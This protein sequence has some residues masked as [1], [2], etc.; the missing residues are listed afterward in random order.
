MLD[1][2]LALLG[3]DQSSK[4]PGAKKDKKD[5]KLLQT[6]FSTFWATRVTKLARVILAERRF[7]KRT[8]L[9]C[10]EDLMKLTLTYE[11][12]RVV[13]ET[14]VTRLLVYNRCR[15]GELEDTK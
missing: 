15:S 9:P 13:M 5:V 3:F 2:K 6:A 10:P 1:I 11:N 12:Y 7:N 8:E 4:V 14:T